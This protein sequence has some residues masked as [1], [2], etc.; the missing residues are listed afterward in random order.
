MPRDNA[1]SDGGEDLRNDA[2]RTDGGLV[3][4]ESAVEWRFDRGGGPGGQHRNKVHTRATI[5]VDLRHLQGPMAVVDRVRGRL[6]ASVTLTENS[7]R[8]QW[9]NRARL[10]ERASELLENA[11]RE[12]RPRRATRPTR[13]SVAE[14]LAAK[15]ERS[16][17]KQMRGRVRRDDS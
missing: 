1:P 16:R 15:R 9:R 12:E 6:G 7:S 14:R 3:V 11:A 17:T 5:T 13:G 8:S 10:I 4:P 2:I